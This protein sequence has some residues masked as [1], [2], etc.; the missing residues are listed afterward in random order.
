MKMTLLKPG[1]G[2]PDSLATVYVDGETNLRAFLTQRGLTEGGKTVAQVRAEKPD[3]KILVLPL[4]E[5]MKRIEAAQD[6]AYLTPWHEIDAE[7]YDEMLNVL[8]PQ[9]WER[10]GSVSI[11][12]MCEYMTS[13]ITGHYA[14]VGNRYFAGQF[15]T[16]SP[17]YA[18][19]AAE[20][21]KITTK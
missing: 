5:A 13:N 7:Q 10:I 9:K 21:L 12:R 15:R 8:P 6:A 20:L 14:Q 19:H 11:F 17:S 16:S 18:E 2:Y 1:S 3:R 4:G